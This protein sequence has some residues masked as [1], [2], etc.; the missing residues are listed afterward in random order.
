[1]GKNKLETASFPAIAGEVTKSNFA[2][3]SNKITATNTPL[4]TYLGIKAVEAVVK[5]VLDNKE[6]R[7]KVK[8]DYLNLSG[9][10]LSKSELYGAEVTTV[11]IAKK[12]ALAKEYEY[13]DEIKSL[14]NE[15][16]ALDLHIKNKKDLLKALKLQEINNGTAKEITTAGLLGIEPAE[17]D[18][19]NSFDLKITFKN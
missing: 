10:S 8:E 18:T 11:S 13:S 14:Q 19:L 3:L 1:M 12:V 17:T 15:V 9:G 16:E 7:N 6:F 2:K 5:E 4:K